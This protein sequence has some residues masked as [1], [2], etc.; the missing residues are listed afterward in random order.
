MFFCA[1]FYLQDTKSSNGTFVNSTRLS[2]ANTESSPCQI[3]HGDTVQFGVEVLDNER[4]ITI[5][6]IVAKLEL[7]HANGKEALRDGFQIDYYSEPSKSEITLMTQY[8]ALTSVREKALQVKLA[9]IGEILEKVQSN[10]EER[11][12]YM[13]EED[14]LLRRIEFLQDKLESVLD[15]SMKNPDLD[16]VSLQKKLVRVQEEKEAYETK[17]KEAV[18]KVLLENLSIVSK[19]TELELLLNAVEEQKDLY[20]NACDKLVTEIK[21]LNEEDG[22]NSEEVKRFKFENKNDEAS[23]R[24]GK[25]SAQE[26][27]FTNTCDLEK[28]PDTDQSDPARELLNSLPKENKDKEN[29]S[30]IVDNTNSSPNVA[31]TKDKAN[32]T[33]VH[34]VKFESD[35]NLERIA[36]FNNFFEIPES[37]VNLTYEETLKP[38]KVMDVNASI[39]N[40]V[41]DNLENEVKVEVMGIHNDVKNSQVENDLL[42]VDDENRSIDKRDKMLQLIEDSIIELEQIKHQKVLDELNVSCQHVSINVLLTS[43]NQ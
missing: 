37:S 31:I 40:H 28:K 15:S 12:K 41:T 16:V 36:P 35:E 39:F 43:Y 34:R 8:M 5:N 10:T 26:P 33:V 17:A 4:N 23:E 13:I 29:H 38:L 19:N 21:R 32:S 6:C 42:V 11:W 2:P 3:Y 9:A 27:H 1:Q 7:Y 30:D 20:K 22:Q 18:E 25:V 14:R 24:G